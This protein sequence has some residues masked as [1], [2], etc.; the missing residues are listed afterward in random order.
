[1]IRCFGADLRRINHTLKVFA[2]A[3]CIARRENLSENEI[4][5]VDFAA[6]LYDIGIREAK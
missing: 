1:M 5:T 6:L 2:L 3:G 4:R